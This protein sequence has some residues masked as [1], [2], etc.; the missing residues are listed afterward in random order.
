MIKLF[1]SLILLC[2]TNAFSAQAIVL[3]LNAPLL[4][5]PNLSSK[6]MQNVRKGQKIYIPREEMSEGNYPEF[7]TTYDRA[8]N[9]V[10]IPSG[11]VKVITN[12]DDEFKT[13]IALENVDPTDYRLEEPIPSTYPFES[14]SFLRASIAYSLGSNL[15]APY[16]YGNAFDRQDFGTDK[17]MRVTVTRKAVHDVYDRFY[18]GLIGYI[19]SA[20]NFIEFKNGR[21]AK[22]SRDQIRV[23][24]WVTFD[25]FKVEQFRL[26]AATGFTFNY[27][28][29]LHSYSS[30]SIGE[31]DRFFTGFSLSPMFATA[32]QYNDIIPNTDLIA[33]VDFSLYMPHTL[34]ADPNTVVE[35]LWPD[36]NTLSVGMKGQVSAFIGIQVKY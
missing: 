8:G 26:S 5:E 2:S 36:E 16:N 27:H 1:L 31:E 30:S 19:S 14:H 24:P 25:A 12:D 15:K 7:F 10:F 20:K 33:G 29:Y 11:Y 6:V 17:A 9:K 32:L 21:T 18:F 13:T 35:G 34:E 22:E 23:G 3:T 4:K 28:K